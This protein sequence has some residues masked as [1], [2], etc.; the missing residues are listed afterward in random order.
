MSRTQTKAA[1][2][3][4]I[5]SW[6]KDELDLETQYLQASPQIPQDA[7]VVT[8]EPDSQG[9][10]RVAS[11]LFL[12]NDDGEIEHF[13]LLQFYLEGPV[14]IPEAS[15]ETYLK[16]AASANQVIPVGSFSVTEEGELVFKY[17]IP[18]SKKNGLDKEEFLEIYLLWMFT[19]DSVS[20][21]VE[22]VLAGDKTLEEAQ[23]E[24]VS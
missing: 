11:I 23:E 1:M 14:K 3:K 6:I 9:Q 8:L 22:E 16:F 7:V 20:G 2:F 15:R 10:P 13:E 19:L 18:V 17:V 4:Q 5:Q 12:P 24:L 21:L